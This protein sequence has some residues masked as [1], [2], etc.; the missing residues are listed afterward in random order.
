VLVIVIVIVIGSAR[1]S[2]TSLHARWFSGT[3]PE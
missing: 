2:A 3:T 1:S